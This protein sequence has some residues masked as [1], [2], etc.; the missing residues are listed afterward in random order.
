MDIPVFEDTAQQGALRCN[1]D[2]PL[3]GAVQRVKTRHPSGFVLKDT[4]CQSGQSFKRRFGKLLHFHVCKGFTVEHIIML[5]RPEKFQEVDS[6][7]AACA[8]KP[9]KQVIADV[10]TLAVPPLVACPRVVY[11]YVA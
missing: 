4:P 3:I 11:R 7:L 9:G 8:L 6:A 5:A 10:G 1:A 2:V